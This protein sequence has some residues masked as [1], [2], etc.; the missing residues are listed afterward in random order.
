MTG[1]RR[2]Q[3]PRPHR[4]SEVRVRSHIDGNQYIDYILGMA[5]VFLG[6]SRPDVGCWSSLTKRVHYANG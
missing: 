5:L 6:H 1:L 2:A 4:L 3:P